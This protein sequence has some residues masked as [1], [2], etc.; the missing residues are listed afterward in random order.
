MS[1]SCLRLAERNALLMRMCQK[2]HCVLLLARVTE[3]TKLEIMKKDDI[4]KD[5]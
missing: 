3:P 2:C 1:L 4:M 5:R